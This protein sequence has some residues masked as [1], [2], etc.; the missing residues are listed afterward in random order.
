[1][2]F[3]ETLPL[4]PETLIK[5]RLE[6]FQ[7][8]FGEV[9]KLLVDS[10]SSIHE[11]SLSSLASFV[12]AENPH[13][14][15]SNCTLPTAL[16]M[17]GMGGVDDSG[18]LYEKIVNVLAATSSETGRI[19]VARLLECQTLKRVLTDIMDQLID[20]EPTKSASVVSFSFKRL[21]DWYE[22]LSSVD[23]T[24]VDEKPAKLVVILPEV[25]SCNPMVLQNLISILQTKM[26]SLPFVLIMGLATSFETF[27]QILPKK[28][29]SMMSLE[30]FRFEQP[31][32][33]LAK[34]L[35]HVRRSL[36]VCIYLFH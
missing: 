1:M 11:Q 10:C 35:D 7:N 21:L 5:A 9:S 2:E 18:I 17:I 16:L 23:S 14:I 28:T 8:H 19:R 32:P 4:E 15:S 27:N 30:T 3:E 12:T 36:S 26:K 13:S 22:S 29:V 25:E 24:A 34:I 31:K 6:S 33:S 20:V